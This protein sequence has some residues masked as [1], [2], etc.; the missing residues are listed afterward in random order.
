MKSPIMKDAYNRIFYYY[1]TKGEFD[2]NNKSIFDYYNEFYEILD[3][4]NYSKLFIVMSLPRIN[5][6]FYLS[7]FKNCCKLRRNKNK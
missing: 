5:Q 2:I 6:R 4:L 1:S 7:L 3:N